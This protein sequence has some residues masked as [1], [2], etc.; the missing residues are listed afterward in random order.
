MDSGVI[1]EFTEEVKEVKKEKKEIEK[2]TKKLK[3]KKGKK[4]HMEKCLG[5]KTNIFSMKPQE[6]DKVQMLKKMYELQ[7]I[8]EMKKQIRNEHENNNI[9]ASHSQFVF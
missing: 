1:K 9:F 7:L 8:S 6:Y 2:K 4:S 3:E 5:E